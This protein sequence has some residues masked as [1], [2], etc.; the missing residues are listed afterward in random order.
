MIKNRTIAVLSLGHGLNDLLAGYYLGSLVQGNPDLLNAGIGLLVY[1]LLAFGGQYPVAMWMEKFSNPQK[2]LIASYTMN[3]MAVAV[4][5]LQPQL[6]IVLLGMASAIYHVAGGSVCARE[7]KTVHIGLFAAPGVA[8]LIAGGYF[9]WQ[10][11]QLTLYLLPAAVLFLALLFFLNI[12]GKTIQTEP[13][14]KEK[15]FMPDRH[16]IIMILLLTVI[17]LRSAV[18][19]IFQLIHEEHYGWLLAIAVAACIG[20]I[21]GGWLAD[22]IGWRLYVFISLFTAAPLIHFFRNEMVLFCTGIGLLQSGIPATTAL[23]I[24]SV[25]GRTERGISLSFGTA[26]LAGGIVFCIPSSFFTRA[27]FIFP[28]IILLMLLLMYLSGREKYG[29]NEPMEPGNNRIIL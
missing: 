1:N 10:G 22:R 25:K 16:D 7:N 29:M 28:F 8:G 14:S 5:F 12:P 13:S 23:L 26:I 21:A 27:W 11:Y 18:W 20:K 19:N 3:A 17:A 2:F 15:N 6:S 4:Y 9:A 24:H